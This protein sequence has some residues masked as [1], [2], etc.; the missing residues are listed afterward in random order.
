MVDLAPLSV[1]EPDGTP[2]GGIVLLQEAFGV[3]DHIEDVGRR[4]AAEGWLCVVPHLFHRTG[5]PQLGYDDLPAVMPHIHEL[6]ADG[7]L[8][9]VDTALAAIALAGIA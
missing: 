9:D 8:A 6:T 3:N 5:D 4:F 2:K 1:H 7:L